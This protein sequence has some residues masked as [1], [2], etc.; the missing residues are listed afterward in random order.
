MDIH[1]T[2]VSCRAVIAAQDFP[3]EVFAT[4]PPPVD[5]AIDKPEVNDKA[6]GSENVP[7]SL[8]GVSGSSHERLLVQHAESTESSHE[9]LHHD[10]WLLLQHEEST[11]C[12][13]GD[14][15]WSLFFPALVAVSTIA[16][17]WVRTDIHKES[18]LTQAACPSQ[19]YM[20]CS[21]PTCL[22]EASFYLLK[23]PNHHP[24][25]LYPACMRSY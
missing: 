24:R 4:L 17:S 25:P 9:L 12:T 21:W 14:M 7:S 6:A 1:A 15:A 8:L 2:P 5:S 19:I 16:L 22:L 18:N 3:L 11:D 20:R 23:T 10:E 13:L